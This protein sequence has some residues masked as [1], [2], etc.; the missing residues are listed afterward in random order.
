MEFDKETY[1]QI[2][3]Y[4]S[5]TLN[6]EDRDALELKMQS[7]KLLKQEVE[8]HKS[9]KH[10]VSGKGWHVSDPQKSIEDI[11]LIKQ[12][13]RSKEFSEIEDKIQ[14]ASDSYFNDLKKSKTKKWK[15]YLVSSVAI[16][17]ILFVVRFLPVSGESLYAEYH[18]WK[19]LPSLT[20]KDDQGS[21]LAEAEDFFHN[22]EYQLAIPIFSKFIDHQNKLDQPL[23]PYVLSYLGA[24]YLESGNYQKALKTFNQLQDGNSLDASRKYWYTTLVYLKQGDKSNAKKELN[25]LIQDENNFNFKKAKELLEQLK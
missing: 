1:D 4:I 22:E 6:D 11:D 5:G 8:L 10:E 7:D 23:N 14:S 21:V 13:R 24:S 12:Y 17:L 18:N 3:A 20:V 15:Y 19:D 16:L 25:L 9:L 2:E